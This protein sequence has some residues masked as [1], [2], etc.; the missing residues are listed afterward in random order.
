[1]NFYSNHL[2]FLCMYC[3]YIT[4]CNSK[5]F[6]V[7]TDDCSHNFKAD[8]RI[9]LKELDKRKRQQREILRFS[10]NGRPVS[11]SRQDPAGVCDSE[12]T[13]FLCIQIYHQIQWLVNLD[14]HSVLLISFKNYLLSFNILSA[15]FSFIY[16]TWLSLPISIQL[17]SGNK[18]ST[19]FIIYHFL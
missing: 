6:G 4:I 16:F 17:Y 10:K 8:K 15:H 13:K 12:S 2:V 1:M 7:C 18:S 14:T 9:V 19:M 3:L 11:Q 5:P